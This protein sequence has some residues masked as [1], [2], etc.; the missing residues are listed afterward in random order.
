MNAPVRAFVHAS[1]QLRFGDALGRRMR[2]G[3]AL[4]GIAAPRNHNLRIALLEEGSKT[5]YGI[6]FQS[7]STQ[8][9]LS[10]KNDR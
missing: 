4:V 10:G 6:E 8:S 3:D 9:T 5:L 1:T 7:P 2:W